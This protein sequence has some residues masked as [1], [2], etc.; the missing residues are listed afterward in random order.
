[1]DGQQR[2]NLKVVYYFLPQYSIRQQQT[3]IYLPYTTL[4]GL[5]TVKYDEL[6]HT[7]PSTSFSLFLSTFT[8]LVASVVLLRFK[9][10][11]L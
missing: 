11:R 5:N 9:L 1:M 6:F 3:F 4:S 10:E 8:V 2:Q 7:F